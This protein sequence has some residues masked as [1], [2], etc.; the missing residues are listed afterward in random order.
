MQ[1]GQKWRE[2]EDHYQQVQY[3]VR[4]YAHH[5]TIIVRNDEDEN[6]DNWKK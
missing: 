2:A 1:H 6:E 5:I 4:S 3:L